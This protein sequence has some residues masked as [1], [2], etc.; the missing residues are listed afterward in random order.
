VGGERED[1]GQVSRNPGAQRM[2]LLALGEKRH[3]RWKLSKKR[4]ERKIGRGRTRYPGPYP[5]VDLVRG[6]QGERGPFGNPHRHSTILKT[7]KGTKGA[8]FGSYQKGQGR[9][10]RTAGTVVLSTNA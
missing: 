10:E 3:Y 5:G 6:G 8:A 4:Q 1:S 7:R 9:K 2:V